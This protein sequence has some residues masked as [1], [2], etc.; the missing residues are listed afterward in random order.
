MT[1]KHEPHGGMLSLMMVEP[2]KRAPEDEIADFNHQGMVEIIV[3]KVSDSCAG[4]KMMVYGGQAEAVD[5]AK[6]RLRD[7]W[8]GYFAKK[9]HATSKQHLNSLMVTTSNVAIIGCHLHLDPED[10]FKARKRYTLDHLVVPTN[11]MVFP[12]IPLSFD[13]VGAAAS[14]G[15]EQNHDDAMAELFASDPELAAETLNAILEDGDQGE[16]LVTLGQIAKAKGLAGIAEQAKVNRS[17][18]YR[19]LSEAGNPSLNS[20]I[21]ILAAMG[22]R[23]RVEPIENAG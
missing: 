17:Q 9:E 6:Q 14:S 8:H 7:T 16:L 3:A 21:A 23:L 1:P 20:F 15:V 19:T 5:A 12:I 10:Y 13:G 11:E 18:L 4:R 22:L 2:R